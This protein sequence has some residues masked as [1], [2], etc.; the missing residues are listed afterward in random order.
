MATS[1]NYVFTINAREIVE[2]S[3]F[4][5]GAQAA[6]ET[7]QS[8]DMQLGLRKLNLLAKQ[9]MGNGDFAPGLKM[10]SRKV[11][12]LFLA[13]D[14]NEYSIGPSGD[15]S[16]RSYVST[17][18]TAAASGGASTILVASI[19]G[20][21]TTN[22][23]GV[24]LADGSLFWTTVNGAPSGATVT[25]T[26]TLPSAANSGARVFAYATKIIRPLQILSASLRDT[27]GND[28]GLTPM[29]VYGYESIPTKSADGTPLAYYY[30]AQRT[31]GLLALDVAPDDVTQV[32]RL[33]YLAPIEDIDTLT[34]DVDFPQHWLRALGYQL[35]IDL[36]PSFGLPVSAEMKLLRDESLAM[37]KSVDPDT[38]TAYFQP[39][40][41]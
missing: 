34:D 1:G 7:I 4:D 17:T 31:S 40:C 5:V 20:I 35:N 22:S 11:G 32:I 23:I 25:L 9:W 30:E 41:D 39:G 16:A 38:T 36:A 26:A 2:T 33:K 29:D 18:L 6:G 27:A 8:E 28:T 15:N 19:A 13:K 12:Y 3:L 21:A 24:E 14:Q 37:A 10:W